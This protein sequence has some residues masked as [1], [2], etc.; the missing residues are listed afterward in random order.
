MD[1]LRGP[2]GPAKLAQGLNEVAHGQAVL[3]AEVRALRERLLDPQH[4]IIM[5]HRR[6]IER[7]EVCFERVDDRVQH[8]EVKIAGA[9]LL[10]G[11]VPMILAII[12]RAMGLF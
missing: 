7:V 1:E 6:R 10:G 9:A 8:I 3:A 2:A 12:A 11:S 4:G 5:D